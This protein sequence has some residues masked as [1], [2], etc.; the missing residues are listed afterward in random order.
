M[1]SAPEVECVVNL[2]VPDLGGLAAEL[3]AHRQTGC[4]RA[5]LHAMH[6]HARTLGMTCSVL[7]PSLMAQEHGIYEKL[8]YRLRNPICL[9]VREQR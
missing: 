5:L 2:L 8:G 7:V 3:T 1:A 4:C 6:A 9:L